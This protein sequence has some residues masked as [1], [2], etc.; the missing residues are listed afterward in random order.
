M[1]TGFCSLFFILSRMRRCSWAR[2]PGPRIAI[3]TFSLAPF[4]LP[5]AGWGKAPA[6]IIAPVAAPAVSMKP[7]RLTLRLSFIGLDSSNSGSRTMAILSASG[8]VNT[9]ARGSRDSDAA[10]LWHPR[11]NPSATSLCTHRG[12]NHGFINSR[13]IPV[14]T[15]TPQTV[16]G[17][18]DADPRSFAAT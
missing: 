18:A 9:T 16:I 8:S 11:S 2:P 7:R 12:T 17:Q 5:T 1:S 6:A 3:L 10:W 13:L 14:H 15:L 4:T